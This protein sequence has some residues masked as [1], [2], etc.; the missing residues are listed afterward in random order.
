MLD[1]EYYRIKN[2]FQYNFNSHEKIMHK[3]IGKWRH[4]SLINEIEILRFNFV[5]WMQI[6]IYMNVIF[7]FSPSMS[8]KLMMFDHTCASL[9]KSYS[10]FFSKINK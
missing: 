8:N 6:Y 5:C 4:L 3:I 7:P 2:N 9:K 1:F 10:D